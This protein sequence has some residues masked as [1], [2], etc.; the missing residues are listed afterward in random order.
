MKLLY[1][2]WFKDHTG[3]SEENINL[4]SSIKT[5][6]DLISWLENKDQKYKKI[7]SNKSILN[8]AINHKIAQAHDLAVN[9]SDE[10]AFFP[11]VTGG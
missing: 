11:P 2:A 4:P 8:I 6:N 9:D 7:F 5:I 1:F 3:V 10:V